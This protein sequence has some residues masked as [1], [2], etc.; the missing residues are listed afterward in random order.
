MPPHPGI[1]GATVTPES[2]GVPCPQT[3]CIP[4]YSKPSFKVVVAVPASE[5][6]VTAGGYLDNYT[7]LPNLTAGTSYS[8]GIIFMTPDAHVYG[9]LVGCDP[10]HEPVADIQAT[11]ES[12]DGRI[13]AAPSSISNSAGFFNTTVPPGPAEVTFTPVQGNGLY[14]GSNIFVSL[15]PGQVYNVGK[16]CL[17]VGVVVTATL[18]SSTTGQKIYNWLGALFAFAA[19]KACER[20]NHGVCFNQGTVVSEGGSP[21]TVAPTTIA[22]ATADL[23]TFYATGYMANTTYITVPQLA[24]GHT[25]NIGRV[26][27]IENGIVGLTP[28]LTYSKAAGNAVSKWGTGLVW[29][30][31]C[32][33]DGFAFSQIVFNTFG[34]ANMTESECQGGQGCNN[35]GSAVEII[36]AP[37]RNSIEVHPDSTIVCNPYYP[38]WPL[39][40]M[41]PVSSNY[42]YLNVTPGRVMNVGGIGLT[43]GTYVLGTVSPATALWSASDCSTDELTWCPATSPGNT[44]YL[45]NNV[46]YGYSHVDENPAG[47]PATY[48]Y[49]CV[50]V[51]PGPSRISISGQTSTSNSTVVYVPPGVWSQLPLPLAL[52][53][54]QHT[55]VVNITGAQIDGRVLDALTGNVLDGSVTVSIS[56]AGS[57]AEPAS[58]TVTGPTGAYSIPALPGWVEVH[59]SSPNFLTNSTWLYVG[60]GTVSA[61]TIYLTPESYLTG[62]V[63][64]PS[65][66][67]LN[68]SSVVVCPISDKGSGC[69]PIIGSGLTNTNGTYFA[70]V[71]AGHLP[72]SAYMVEANAPGFLSNSTWVNVTLPG[73]VYTADTIILQPILGSTTAASPHHSSGTSASAAYVFGFVVDN[74]TGLGVP[75]ASITLDPVGGGVPILQSGSISD[76][77]QFNLTVSLG[78][79]WFNVTDIGIYYPWSGFLIV[80]GSVPYIN[81]STIRLVHLGYLR[82]RIVV[83]PWRTQVTVLEGIGVQAIVTVSNPNH[84]IES[85][86]QTDTGG[87]FNISAT[88]AAKDQVYAVATG[89][90]R[91]TAKQGFLENDTYV[92]VTKNGSLPFFIMG[93]VIYTAYTGLVRDASTNNATPV[94]YGS[95]ALT[96]ATPNFAVFSDSEELS[97]GGEFTIFM[98]PGNITAGL[99]PASQVSAYMPHNFTYHFP[100][101]WFANNLSL[102]ENIS[103]A[104]I[105]QLPNVSLTHFGWIDVQVGTTIPA[106]GTSTSVVPYAVAS[107]TVE[108]KNATIVSAP[109][110]IA[111]ANGYLN[112]T[113][114]VGSNVSV[115]LSAP[116]FNST[117]VQ[118]VSI[119]ESATT[120][121]NGTGDIVGTIYLLPWG[122]VWGTVVDS[123]L[124]TPLYSAGVTVSNPNGTGSPGVTTNGAG[125]FMSD[126]PP[127]AVDQVAVTLNGYLTNNTNVKVTNGGVGNLT[128]LNMTGLGIVA[129]RV[130]GY[131][132]D[133]AVYGATVTVC[134]IAAPLCLNSNATTNGTGYFWVQATPGRDVITITAAGFSE[135]ATPGTILVASD[136]W[137]WAGVFVIDQYSTVSGTVLGNPSGLALYEANASLCSPIA[138]PGEPTGPCFVTVLTNAEGQFSLSVPYGSYIL[139]INASNYNASYLP[140]ALGPGESQSVG[141]IFLEQYGTVSGVI[142]GQDTDAPVAGA[143]IQACELWSVGNCTGFVGVS[144]SGAYELSGPPGPYLLVAAGPNYQEAY[145]STSFLAGV[146][147]TVFPI[148]LIPTGTNLLY[149][150]Q[151]T[152]VGNEVG[153]ANQTPLDGAV[154]TAGSNYAAATNASGGFS[155]SIPWGTYVLT[156]QQNGYTA[157]SRSVIVHTDLS[158]LNFVLPQ[159]VYTVSGTILDGLTGNPV[160]GAGLIVGGVQ[161]TSSEPSGDYALTLPNGTF[162]V[163]VTP[164]AISTENYVP[165]SFTVGISGRAVV[166]NLLMY[167][168]SAIVSGLVVNSLTGA[169]IQNA[170]V[171][172]TGATQGGLPI[173]AITLITTATG[174]FS[175]PMYF[176]TYEMNASADGY[177]PAKTQTVQ[178]QSS[179]AGTITVSMTPVSTTASGPSAN[180]NLGSALL[181]AGIAAVGVVGYLGLG[182]WR[183]GSLDSRPARRSARSESSTVREG[184]L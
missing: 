139:E 60:S 100:L 63:L 148:Y 51:T 56:P 78:D 150:L 44:Y 12:R 153:S 27:L 155:I 28:T 109:S 55:T 81:E 172:L 94:A 113:A 137:L 57:N 147:T 79:Y 125:F 119:N 142:L 126:A 10:T 49:F 26:N 22:P 136:S 141:T 61:S 130:L 65:G 53:S 112:M 154:V 47:C 72:L 58:A 144:A 76:I 32:S 175:V 123:M 122:W 169:P 88:N 19:A 38:T 146:T 9:T 120:Y 114:P 36:A 31:V 177:L 149:T 45:A 121:V 180:F 102:L 184:S 46:T 111:D 95:V 179:V 21:S 151:G 54:P 167:P 1:T 145:V 18:Y 165:V 71:P 156:A 118:N 23:I 97:G 143:L 17:Q 178:V 166:R 181:L 11:G 4:V 96:T 75:G 132:G 92:N 6:L 138:L 82:G 59:A 108:T 124:G 43:P 13:I 5:I 110:T 152:V 85:S 140:V 176:G 128:P 116:D 168:G 37:L 77:G 25:Y 107:A 127:G 159:A 7:I 42:T 129:G 62:Q 106:L 164:P 135:N 68:T 157:E 40:G 24:P 34:G 14:F 83:D 69:L 2:L 66:Y 74:A 52:A 80:N 20:D 182:P 93:E 161:L 89:G 117:F 73:Q 41:L 67:P 15:Q 3:T 64:G 171:V 70:L 39:P 163:V 105:W 133:A 160:G 30:Q 29:E 174:T 115:A 134:P 50:A 91:G 101:A 87:F 33:M 8:V 35:L 162:T 48:Y 98:P 99:T 86:G 16:V 183:T 158:G 104:A 173:A 84:E 170:T 103:A 90:G 131:P